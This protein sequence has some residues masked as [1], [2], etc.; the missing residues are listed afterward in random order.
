MSKLHE[1]LA[2]EQT[3]TA[4]L[5]VALVVVIKTSRTSTLMAGGMPTVPVQDTLIPSVT[6]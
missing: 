2:A 3:P 6:P 4:A 5:P 1:L